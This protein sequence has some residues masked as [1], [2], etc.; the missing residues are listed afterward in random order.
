LGLAQQLRFM[1]ISVT[2]T[3]KE[4]EDIHDEAAKR[5]QVSRLAG[6]P[7]QRIGDMGNAVSADFIGLLGEVAFSQIF[8]AERDKDIRARSG[9]IDFTS[10]GQAV[11]VKSSKHRNAH[12][13]VPAYFFDGKPGTKE[14]CHA[15]VLMLVDLTNRTI[16]FAGWASREEL[17]IPE[18]L[19]YFK[20]SSRQSF[21]L[22]QEALHQLDDVTATWLVAAAKAKGHRV[23]LTESVE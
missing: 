22:P 8:D 16:T 5:H 13:L 17:I 12:L 21:V 19:D 20:G 23:C 18:R 14:Y 11:E 3:E 4:M 6:H 1:R 2:F 10:N 9:S 7:D 15:Y